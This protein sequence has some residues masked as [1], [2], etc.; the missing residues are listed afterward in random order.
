MQV[1]PCRMIGFEVS[2]TRVRQRCLVRRSKIRRTPEEPGNVLCE[3]VQRLAR[4]VPPRNALGIGWK[5]G[6]VAIPA[7]WQFTPLY[8]L[9]LVRQLGILRAIGGKEFHPLAPRLSAARSY[10][11]G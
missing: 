5:D 1:S 6:K 4:S 8:Q 2:R 10:P 7:G 3:N 11:S 9:D